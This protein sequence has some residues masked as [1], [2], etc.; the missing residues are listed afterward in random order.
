MLLTELQGWELWGVVK[1][2]VMR[3]V[4]LDFYWYGMV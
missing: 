4:V 2:I 3:R 1:V